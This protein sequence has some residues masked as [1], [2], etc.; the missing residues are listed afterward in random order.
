MR[1]DIETAPKPAPT[2]LA[3]KCAVCGRR[4]RGHARCLSCGILVGPEHVE[5]RLYGGR[6]LSCWRVAREEMKEGI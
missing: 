1:L 2:S 4:A 5:Q 6:C 3:S